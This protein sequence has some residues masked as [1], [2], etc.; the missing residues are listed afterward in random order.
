M[1]KRVLIIS[2][3]LEIGGAESSLIGYLDALAKRTDIETELFL[4]SHRGPLMKY[5]PKEI[6]LL[7]ESGAYA[8]LATPIKQ[9]IKKGRFLIAAGRALGKFKARRFVKK[10]AVSSKKSAVALEYSHKYTKCFMPKISDTEY[11]LAV[12]FL[13]PHYFGA[14]KVKAKCK[15]AYIHTDYKYLTVDVESELKMWNAYDVIAAVSEAV[16][17]CFT[18]L[19]PTLAGKVKVIENINPTELIR[20]H[21]E[22]VY[23][24][25][26]TEEG[27]KILSI[28]RFCEQKNFESIPV[29]M[30]LL[31]KMGIKAKW[32]IIGF[33]DD[34]LIKKAIID[35]K[36]KNDVILLGKKTNPYPYIKACDIYAQPSRYEGKAV[37][38]L[39]AQILEKPVI[40][41]NYATSS[42]QLRDGFDGIIAP[43]DNEGFVDRLAELID[44]GDKRAY[45]SNNCKKSDYSNATA[46]EMLLDILHD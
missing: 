22:E 15:V 44:D 28:G 33:G 9:V 6:T 13:T 4:Y 7:P 45:L 17:N 30:A 18:D 11:D 37:T 46:V 1:K 34:S 23:A 39:E 5:I 3:G 24:D 41:T 21:A 25:E 2:H 10:H 14:E 20:K 38:V 42:S 8:C 35:T 26:M 43:M 16:K 19:F 32:Y 29:K 27:I 36:T 12:S 31:K 40:I